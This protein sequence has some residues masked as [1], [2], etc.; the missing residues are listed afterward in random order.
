MVETSWAVMMSGLTIC[1]QA[2]SKAFVA[3][4]IMACTDRGGFQSDCMYLDTHVT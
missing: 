4:L 2:L 3:I 1:M